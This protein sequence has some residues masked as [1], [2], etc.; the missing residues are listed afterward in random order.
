MYLGYLDDSG[1]P[2]VHAGSPTPTYTTAC[3]LVRDAHWVGLFEDHNPLSSLP[4]PELRF[5][6]APGGP[7]DGT[8]SWHGNP[9]NRL[10]AGALAELLSR[11]R[12]LE[13]CAEALVRWAREA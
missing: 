10:A 4:A 7:W 11:R 13:R 5:A 9:A 1:D 12:S 8:R 6:D 3:V 2:G